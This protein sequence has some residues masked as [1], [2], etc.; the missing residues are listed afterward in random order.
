MSM[1]EKNRIRYREGFFVLVSNIDTE[2]DRMLDRYYG[3]TE[4][5]SVFN[6]DKEYVGLLPLSK[7]KRETVNGEIMQDM[8]TLI[9]YMQ[10][11]KVTAPT[12]RSVSDCIYDLQSLDCYRSD[13]DT[14]IVS[15]PNRQVKAAYALFGYEI[16]DK[17]SISEYR[18]RIYLSS[19]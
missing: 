5:E 18:D 8:I 14:L 3:R 16:P 12:G 17:V 15:A 13:Q 10:I 9:V 2:P 6:C 11:R 4:I 7:Q 1:R 19:F